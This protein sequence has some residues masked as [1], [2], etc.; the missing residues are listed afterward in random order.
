LPRFPT[1][2]P[3]CVLRVVRLGV[4]RCSP[5]RASVDAHLARTRETLRQV[6]AGID[7]VRLIDP[8]DVFCTASLCRPYEDHTVYFKDLIHVSPAGAERFYRAF[9]DDIRWA[10]TGE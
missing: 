9:R 2:P 10:L 3:N 8:I 6:T 4:D 5:S 7:G 1:R